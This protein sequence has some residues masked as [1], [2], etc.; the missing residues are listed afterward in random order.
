MRC[1]GSVIDGRTE[2]VC[3][4]MLRL[5]RDEAGHCPV[6]EAVAAR[7]GWSVQQGDPGDQS[8]LRL[9]H[10][11][12][13]GSFG[14]PVLEDRQGTIGLA[15]PAAAAVEYEIGRGKHQPAVVAGAPFGEAGS[16]RGDDFRS[17]RSGSDRTAS[18]SADSPCVNH[19]V[20][21][22]PGQGGGKSVRVR[23]LDRSQG[24]AHMI[25]L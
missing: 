8:A 16:R 20:R 7:K 24:E 18:A 14:P 9:Q 3:K 2:L 19:D 10:G 5:T 15:I 1:G 22:R 4:E 13:G 25:A 12:L 23:Q 11:Q 21:I 17:A 6:E